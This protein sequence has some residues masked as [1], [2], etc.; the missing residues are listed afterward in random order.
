LS[1]SKDKRDPA[2][3]SKDEWKAHAT[4]E[5]SDTDYVS[6]SYFQKGEKVWYKPSTERG[7]YGPYTIVEYLGDENYTIKKDSD[8]VEHP[9][10]VH[11]DELE[12][13]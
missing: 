9:S 7:M 2:N 8:G 6:V 5:G 13:V 1:E 10:P 11:K 4:H 3:I 12:R